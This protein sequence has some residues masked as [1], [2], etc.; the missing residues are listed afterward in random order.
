MSVAP[1]A[2]SRAPL[3]PR[4]WAQSIRPRAPSA[5]F[6]RSR[7]DA[8]CC[9]D[10]PPPSAESSGASSSASAGK[11]QGGPSPRSVLDPDWDRALRPADRA[12]TFPKAR[13]GEPGG[14]ATAA[15]EGLSAEASA[16]IR[17]QAASLKARPRRPAPAPRCL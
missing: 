16:E 17:G 13:R 8:G 5:V 1:L 15:V 6:P 2:D 7:R 3:H 11:Q 4:E 9:S 12:P 10:A 14:A